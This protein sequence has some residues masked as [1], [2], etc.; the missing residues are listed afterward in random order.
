MPMLSRVAAALCVSLLFAGSPLHADWREA[1]PEAQLMGGG[2]LRIFGFAIYDAELWSVAR[3]PADAVAMRAPFAL[4]LS[5]RRSISRDDLVEA[6]LKE[7]RRLA[8][9]EP[10]PAQLRRWEDEMQQAFVDVRA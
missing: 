5:Y 3:A 8:A 9:R 10:D 7:I 6:S 1:L 2:E 4:Q